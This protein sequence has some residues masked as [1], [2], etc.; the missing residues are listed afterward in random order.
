MLSKEIESINAVR[1]F[2]ICGPPKM[3][4]ETPIILESLGVLPKNIHL[5]W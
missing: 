1:K 4:N 2:L 3:N 5:V